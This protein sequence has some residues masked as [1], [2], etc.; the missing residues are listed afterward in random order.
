MNILANIGKLRDGR[1]IIVIEKANRLEY[2]VASGYDP[3]AKPGEQWSSG[4]YLY[5]LTDLACYITKVNL[6]IGYDRMGE[7]AE[8]AVSYL[9]DNRELEEFLCD[10]SIDLEESER[11]YF[12]LEEGDD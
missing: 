9:D 1:N 3:D 2:V 10:R 8:N 7:I 4:T 5:S 11:K 6:T 12:Q